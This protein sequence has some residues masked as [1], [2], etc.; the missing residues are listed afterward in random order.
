LL[1]WHKA[2][3]LEQLKCSVA[4]R[5][6]HGL[7]FLQRVPAWAT[8]WLLA[9][10]STLP[11]PPEHTPG[12]ALQTPCCCGILGAVGVHKMPTRSS[13][14]CLRT[15]HPWD[16]GLDI[17]S[18]RASDTAGCLDWLAPIAT[19]QASPCRAFSHHRGPSLVI[20]RWMCAPALLRQSGMF[21]AL[22]VWISPR[23]CFFNEPIAHVPLP[24]P[25]GWLACM[26]KGAGASVGTAKACE[27][28]VA[29]WL[30]LGP[31]PVV[32]NLP[33]RSRGCGLRI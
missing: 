23:H 3:A 19:A 1:L 20:V 11:P 12:F 22:A 27:C 32:D 4:A 6:V 24:L 18:W 9:L 8:D 28:S 29:C 2:V 26:R 5:S 7:F 31:A 14:P 33:R 17:D 10:A 30:G 21:A 13:S 15:L 25:A 16:L